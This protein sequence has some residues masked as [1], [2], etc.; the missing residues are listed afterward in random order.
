MYGNNYDGKKKL[1][2]IKLGFWYNVRKYNNK[3][4]LVEMKLGFWD[5]VWKY[6]SKKLL[7]GF[8]I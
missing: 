3:K 2:E 6:N 8:G 5:N 7:E 1:I 4:K